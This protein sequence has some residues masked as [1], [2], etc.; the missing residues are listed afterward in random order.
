MRRAPFGLTIS[1]SAFRQRSA[2]GVSPENAAQ[3]LVPPGATWQRS[4]SFLMQKPQPLHQVSDWLYQRQ[5]VSRQMLPPMVPIL[6]RTGE[7]TVAAA[8]VRTGKC[9]RRYEDFSTALSVV[10]APIST[11]PSD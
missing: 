5:R 7:A 2:A 11:A 1:T 4:P 10:S 9:W 8:S 6:R 3:H